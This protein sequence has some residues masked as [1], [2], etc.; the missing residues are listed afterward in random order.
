[1]YVILKTQLGW[2][3]AAKIYENLFKDLSIKI[4]K[5]VACAT[6]A[7]PPIEKPVFFFTSSALAIETSFFFKIF[8]NLFKEHLLSPAIKQIKK[9]SSALNNKLLTIAPT[10]HLN[11]FAASC[12]VFAVVS[13]TITSNLESNCFINS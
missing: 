3:A 5:L 10:S 7:T 6:G 11:E 4:S 8:F 12:A 2:P 9:I 1:L 13:K